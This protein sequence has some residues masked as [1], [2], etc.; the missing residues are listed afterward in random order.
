ML[1]R[2]QQPMV[3]FFFP[4]TQVCLLLS[5]NTVHPTPIGSRATLAPPPDHTFLQELSA[6]DGTKPYSSHGAFSENNGFND[7]GI[8]PWLNYPWLNNTGDTQGFAPPPE[9]Y[10][11]LADHAAVPDPPIAMDPI[12]HVGTIRQD[13]KQQFVCL[14]EGCRYPKAFT[15]SSDL[16]RHMK[17]R[18]CPPEFDCTFPGCD[19]WGDKGFHRKDKLSDHMRQKHRQRLSDVGTHLGF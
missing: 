13:T 7:H 1:H 2:R 3:G 12:P 5:V 11:N 10:G 17:S 18:H 16:A 4:L 15:R 8:D 14:Q 6:D 19:R 9:D